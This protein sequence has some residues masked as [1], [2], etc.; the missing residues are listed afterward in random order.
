MQ[1]GGHLLSALASV[2]DAEALPLMYYLSSRY[3]CALTYLSAED[4]RGEAALH[5]V[6]IDGTCVMVHTMMSDHLFRH[7][8]LAI[9]LSLSL[10]QSLRK[11]E[12]V[13]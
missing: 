10:R 9:Q 5:V 3:R 2:E 6:P 12:R 4:D 8:A 7:E 1:N 13:F 11:K